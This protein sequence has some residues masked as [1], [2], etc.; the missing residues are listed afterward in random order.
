MNAMRTPKKNPDNHKT[1]R[2]PL[3][4]NTEWAVIARKLAT[5]KKQPVSWLIMSLI[6]DAAAQN[7]PD[8]K[9]PP[10]PWDSGEDK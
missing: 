2:T 4:L 8:E 3:Q 7:M 1:P 10:L 9:L 6:A 5:L